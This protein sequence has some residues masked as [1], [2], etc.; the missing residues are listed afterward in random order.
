MT[1]NEMLALRR[2]L[3]VGMAIVTA[4]AAMPPLVVPRRRP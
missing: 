4:L 2:L 1:D 3:A